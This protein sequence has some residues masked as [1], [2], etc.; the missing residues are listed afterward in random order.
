MGLGRLYH[1][2]SEALSAARRSG[3]ADLQ[4]VGLFVRLAD[5]DHHREAITTRP[6]LLS[7]V[8]RRASMPAR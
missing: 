5:P 3:G 4:L 2:G 7:A 8:A 1:G 6:L